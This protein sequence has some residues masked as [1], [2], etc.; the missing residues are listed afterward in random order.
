M[1]ILGSIK[2][3]I[4]TEK[5]LPKLREKYKDK[6]I[7]FISGCF[8]ILHTGH[9]ILFNRARQLG[10]VLVAGVGTDNVIKQLKGS[11]RPINLQNDR[12]L[13]VAAMQDV[14]YAILN[15]DVLE[16]GE[17]DWRKTMTLLKPNIFTINED[18][19]KLDINK[20]VCDE[21]GVEFIVLSRSTLSGLNPTSTTEIVKKLSN[22]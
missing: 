8:D 22:K 4:L 3:K 2:K 15:Q 1:E 14:D 13:L 17:V 18:N 11:T 21:L 6:K 7:V 20:E 5:D 16:K 12:L 19:A 9:A 10:D